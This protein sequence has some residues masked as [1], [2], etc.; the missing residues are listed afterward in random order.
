[1][2]VIDDKSV[3]KARR[4][5]LRPLFADRPAY[6]RRMP[7]RLHS[8]PTKQGELLARL[9]AHR[10]FEFSDKSKSN[11]PVDRL[12]DSGFGIRRCPGHP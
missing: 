5:E 4:K 9:E 10:S 7:R 8:S 3:D 1:M 12:A 6:E 11:Q 2:E